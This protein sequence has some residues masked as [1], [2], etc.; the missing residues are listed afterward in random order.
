MKPRYYLNDFDTLIIIYPH[1]YWEYFNRFNSS[2]I[3]HDY[4]HAFGDM[5]YLG[6]L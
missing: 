4:P 1:G 2:W 3:P 6:P 5:T